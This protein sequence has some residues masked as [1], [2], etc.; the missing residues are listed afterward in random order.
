[1]TRDKIKDWQ[2]WLYWTSPFSY[3]VTSIALNEFQD[4]SRYSAEDE[5]AFLGLYSIPNERGLQWAG[6]GF[7]VAVALLFTAASAAALTLKRTELTSGTRRADKEEGEEEE[8]EAETDGRQQQR[9]QQVAITV[10]PAV[11]SS[12]PTKSLATF[13]SSQ[14]QLPFVPVDLAWSDIRYS[15]RV[16]E[17]DEAGKPRTYDRALL[18]GISGYARTGELTALMGSSGAGVS[19]HATAPGRADSRPRSRP[20]AAAFGTGW[21]SMRESRTDLLSRAHL[22]VCLWLLLSARRKRL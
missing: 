8:D 5:A 13:S 16:T 21:L 6:V 17:Q 4:G 22:R 18:Q 2:I 11:A 3:S 15:V 20:H 9:Q 7:L 1:M 12:A 10:Q 14:V 19:A